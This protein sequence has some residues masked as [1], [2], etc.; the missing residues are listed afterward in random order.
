MKISIVTPTYNSEKSIL[1][2]VQSLINQKNK[3]FEH[4]IVDNLSSDNTLEI[5]KNIYSKNNITEKLQI[6]SEKDEGISDAFNKGINASK[7]EIINIL[8]SDDHYTS[9]SVLSE[10]VKL[11]KNN[12]CVIAHGDVYFNDP[13][14]GSNIR[15]P[16]LCPPS[17]AMPFNH[18][19]MFVKKSV[20][21]QFGF[22][23]TS[24]SFA[25]DFE[26]VC[27]LSKNISDMN[28]KSIYFNNFPLVEMHAGGASWENEI[29]SLYE[30]KR[31][32][33]KYEMWNFQARKNY[34][35]RILRT[36]LK[37]VL[38]N[39]GM[40]KIVSSWRKNKWGN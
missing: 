7:G 19:T 31:A 37:S 11:F 3:E 35:F 12:E 18:P 17:I 5:I 22:Y 10:V 16:L 36:K 28:S 13:V 34:V 29:A 1:K 39:L 27:R 15:K 8:N 2:N 4:I 32:L 38:T 9:D 30:V 20:Y 33:K 23:D 24:Y 6:I 26:F 21:E 14:Y 40:E 25:M